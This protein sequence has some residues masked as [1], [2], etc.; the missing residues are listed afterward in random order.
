[1]GKYNSCYKAINFRESGMMHNNLQFGLILILILILEGPEEWNSLT[2]GNSPILVHKQKAKKT[3]KSKDLRM[4]NILQAVN[5]RTLRSS[6]SFI[7]FPET[8][9]EYL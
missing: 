8:P 6:K 5:D 7:H 2:L 3:K 1:I 4:A 9:V